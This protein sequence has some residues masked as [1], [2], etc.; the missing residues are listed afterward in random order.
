MHCTSLLRIILHVISARASENGGFFFMAEPSPV[1]EL[2]FLPA[3]YRGWTRASERRVHDNLHA[4]AQNAAI[5]SPKSE[6]KPYLEVFSR[7]GLLRDFLND[8][9]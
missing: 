6:E 3:T 5:F 7:F 9:I 1:P 2:S 4:Y 8:K